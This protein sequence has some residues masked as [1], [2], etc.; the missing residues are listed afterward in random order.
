MFLS[1]KDWV[2]LTSFLGTRFLKIGVKESLSASGGELLF[3]RESF[4]LNCQEMKIDE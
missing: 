3:V 4:Q 2:S 1:S